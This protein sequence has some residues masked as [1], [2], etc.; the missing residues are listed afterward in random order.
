[1]VRAL[2]RIEAIASTESF[3]RTST[4]HLLKRAAF[5]W[6]D[7]FSVVAPIRITVPH[8]T[9]GRNVSYRFRHILKEREKT[10]NMGEKKR[11]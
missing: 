6:N 11:Q 1:M 8:S 3:S 9:C 7:G 5:T 2:S 10:A 4:L